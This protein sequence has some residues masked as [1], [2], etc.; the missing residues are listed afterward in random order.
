FCHKKSAKNYT[1]LFI[2][3]FEQHHVSPV[4]KVLIFFIFQR[5]IEHELNRQS[6]SDITTTL[7]SYMII[8]VCVSITVCTALGRYNSVSRILVSISIQCWVQ[9]VTESQESAGGVVMWK[10]QKI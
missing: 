3:T 5:S 6:Q 9:G 1:R 10:N 4:P 2:S 8:F 7:L